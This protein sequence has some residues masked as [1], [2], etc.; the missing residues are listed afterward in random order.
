MKR[1]QNR[2]ILLFHPGCIVSHITGRSCAIGIVKT[3][4]APAGSLFSSVRCGSVTGYKGVRWM[5]I[6][7]QMQRP[8]LDCSAV[9]VEPLS[10]FI[11]V[12]CRPHKVRKTAY[13]V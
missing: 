13:C 12:C 2:F 9:T 4:P 11:L 3:I 6:P 5:E 10:V 8:G 1:M 7:R